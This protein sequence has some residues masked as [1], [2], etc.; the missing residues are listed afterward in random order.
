LNQSIMQKVHL[1]SSSLKI[2][3]GH[4]ISSVPR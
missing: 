1:Q 2:F 4:V 3:T